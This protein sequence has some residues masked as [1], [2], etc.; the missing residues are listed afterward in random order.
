MPSPAPNGVASGADS[1]ARIRTLALVGPAASGSP[2]R[3]PVAAAV[4]LNFL[5]QP[6]PPPPQTRL[7]L[8]RPSRAGR[9]SRR[10]ER[11]GRGGSAQLDPPPRGDAAGAAVRIL[12]V[13]L[14]P[15]PP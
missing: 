4:A 12:R 11:A 14:L 13:A 10:A 8:R 5:A 3:G 1:V 6:D 15:L 7:A 9:R 2:L